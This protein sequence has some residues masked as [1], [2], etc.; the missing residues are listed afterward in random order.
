[1]AHRTSLNTITYVC[2]HERVADCMCWHIYDARVCFFLKET[3][4]RF[5]YAIVLLMHGRWFKLCNFK[6]VAIYSL[7]VF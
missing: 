7:K 4:N 6:K 2:L 3:T 5:I 1:M